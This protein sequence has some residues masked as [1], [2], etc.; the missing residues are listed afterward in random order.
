MPGWRDAVRASDH[1]S[2]TTGIARV[3][4]CLNK[5]LELYQEDLHC[6]PSK[7]VCGCVGVWVC[8]V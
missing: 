7:W 8:G 4:T 1:D 6:F 3:G 5:K 2:S